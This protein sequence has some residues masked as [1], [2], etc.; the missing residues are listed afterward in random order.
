MLAMG[1][2]P[3][4]VTSLHVANAIAAIARDGEFRSAKL[5]REGGPEQV[6]RSVGTSAWHFQLVRRGMADVVARPGQVHDAFRD[7]GPQGLSVC[8]KTGTA[9]V[10]ARRVAAG[11][12]GRQSVTLRGD[13][14]WFTGFAPKDNPQIAFAVV[15]EYVEGGSGGRTAAPVAAEVVRICQQLGYTR[16]GRKKTPR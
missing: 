11:A 7:S 8:G 1:Q 2:G 6:R 3:I 5:L 4:V 13:M 12:D 10:Q 9:Q 15:L 14:V 16:P